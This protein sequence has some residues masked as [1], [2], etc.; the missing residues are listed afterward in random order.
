MKRHV[1]FLHP[2]WP[3]PDQSSGDYQLVQLIRLLRSAD[4]AVTVVARDRLADPA[5]KK[6]YAL[7][8]L[9]MGCDLGEL[10]SH[11]SA[12]TSW[13]LDLA[14]QTLRSI[15]ERGRFH[16]A[17][18]SFWNIA[19]EFAPFLK[20]VSP[21]TRVLVHSWDVGYM[22]EGRGAALWGHVPEL[23]KIA[24]RRTTEM[25]A[26]AMADAVLAVTDLDG[27]IIREGMQAELQA[28]RLPVTV[29]SVPPVLTIPHVHPIT[30]DPKGYLD[31]RDFL[32]VGGFRHSPN[33]DAVLFL[34]NEVWPLIH[35][36]IPSAKLY[37]VGADAPPKIREL[38]SASVHILGY[39][40]D[41]DPLL[42]QVRV[43]I[44][45]LR[46]GAGMKG[47]I[48]QAMAAGLPVV[49]TPIGAEGMPLI[50]G[51]HV[52]IGQ[53]A[54]GL[55]DA[56]VR[57]YGGQELWN[58][59]SKSGQRLV[60]TLYSDIPVASHFFDALF[61]PLKVD[62]LK[63]TETPAE[64]KAL[65]KLLD[66]FMWYLERYT[67]QLALAS[68][69]ESFQLSPELYAALLAQADL[70]AEAGEWEKARLHVEQAARI[71]PNAFG[72][73]AMQA[74]ISLHQQQP[75]HALQLAERIL[76]IDPKHPDAQR[77]KALALLRLN[78]AKQS[79]ELL[80]SAYNQHANSY[81]NNYRLQKALVSNL[82]NS[83]KVEG[84]INL[85]THAASAAMSF[86]RN[87]DEQDFRRRLKSI[88]DQISG[89]DS[90]PIYESERSPAITGGFAGKPAVDIIIPI[91]N[92]TPIVQKCI[93]SVLRTAP[94]AHLILVNDDTPAA[95]YRIIKSDQISQ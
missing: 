22:R 11:P 16:A 52:M 49:T 26:Y 2:T 88:V 76:S 68:F 9:K 89:P 13:G 30:P 78:Q 5:Q 63:Q 14:K 29:R 39:V 62:T 65:N 82:S 91:Y 40:P 1:L 53:T 90:I 67:P 75:N 69:A 66:G 73:L 15:V 56:A 27:E 50:E 48:S 24:F 4:H 43:S 46:F 8:L 10:F 19:L 42:D 60:D 74:E 35:R 12:N 87:A 70:E 72:V 84:V 94:W 6:R 85:L 18:V 77:I 86:G 25:K 41:L 80:I 55:A 95:C 31:R 3:R 44:A 34:V 79:V 83:S 57:L 71:A 93:D 33:V 59:L 47:K 36:R 21:E 45:P 38:E 32:F 92:N 64:V 58:R 81:P 28:R 61:S 54:Q 20:Q 37:V 51:E 17:I 7:E 23:R